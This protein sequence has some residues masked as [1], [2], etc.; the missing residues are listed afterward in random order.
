[1]HAAA[2]KL[3]SKIVENRTHFYLQVGVLNEAHGCLVRGLE[4]GFNLLIADR[5]EY[6][7]NIA[8]RHSA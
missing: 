1:M 7:G 4:Q 6:F 2:V 8:D 3:D 5:S